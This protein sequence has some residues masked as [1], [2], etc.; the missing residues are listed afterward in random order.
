MRCTWRNHKEERLVCF[1]SFIKKAVSFLSHHISDIF[2][3]VAYGWIL[4][5][6]ERAVEIVVCKRI[7]KE[8]L[9]T[10]APSPQ[11]VTNALTELVNPAG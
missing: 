3:L 7:E 8:V 1:Y 5:A 4:I 10:L 6:L 2:A 11:F 9:Q